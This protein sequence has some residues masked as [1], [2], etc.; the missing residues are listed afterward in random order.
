MVA[1]EEISGGQRSPLQREVSPQKAPS[2]WL[3]AARLLSH[4]S[5]TIPQAAARGLITLI[6][7]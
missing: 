1:P 7:I 3:G 6:I 5:N 2:R 4:A